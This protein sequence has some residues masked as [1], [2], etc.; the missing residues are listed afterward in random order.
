M[1]TYESNG[2]LIPPISYHDVW[3]LKL[4]HTPVPVTRNTRIRQKEILG[5]LV[6]WSL[7]AKDHKPRKIGDLLTGLTAGL[8]S[9]SHCILQT[10]F[11]TKNSAILTSSWL[12]RPASNSPTPGFLPHKQL[13]SFFSFC[14]TPTTPQVG[15]LPYCSKSTKLMLH[16]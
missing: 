10:S 14:E 6:G 8:R 4:S 11:Y 2:T 16:Q 5:W 13:P 9:W 7:E 15:I 3:E 12:A 1:V